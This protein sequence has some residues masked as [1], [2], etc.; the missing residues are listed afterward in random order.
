MKVPSLRLGTWQVCNNHLM[1]CHLN[2][3]GRL[4]V[5]KN[6]RRKQYTY[7]ERTM[8]VSRTYV[9]IH[10]SEVALCHPLES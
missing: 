2:G 3:E 7:R 4:P 8:M 5:A 1:N 9:L 10:D 6:D